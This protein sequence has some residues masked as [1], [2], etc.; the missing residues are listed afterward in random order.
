MTPRS[1]ADLIRKVGRGVPAKP[2]G[3]ERLGR[4]ASPHPEPF[5]LS[6]FLHRNRY[7]KQEVGKQDELTTKYA[8]IMHG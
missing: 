1:G 7:K 6:A 3:E 5:P 2:F 4:D 8:K